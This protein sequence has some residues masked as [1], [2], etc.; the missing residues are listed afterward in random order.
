MIRADNRLRAGDGPHDVR[1]PS[2]VK[3][4]V[5]KGE[6]LRAAPAEREAAHLC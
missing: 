4:W 1:P 3:V 6:V 2:A 5:V